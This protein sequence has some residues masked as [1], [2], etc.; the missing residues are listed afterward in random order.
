LK[1]VTAALNLASTLILPAEQRVEHS[2]TVVSLV[3]YDS[4]QTS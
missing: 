2:T 1:I 4:Q 3:A